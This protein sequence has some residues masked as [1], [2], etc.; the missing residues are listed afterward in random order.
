M[1]LSIS[2]TKATVKFKIPILTKLFFELD[3][4]HHSHEVPCNLMDD[5]TYMVY[6]ILDSDGRGANADLIEKYP[7][8]TDK[9]R[10]DGKFHMIFF[11]PEKFI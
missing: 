1:C 4:W 8:L 2:T 11:Y 7:L 3:K 9:C 10:L 5:V 6:V